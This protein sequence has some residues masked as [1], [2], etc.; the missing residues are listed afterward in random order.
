[1]VG[2]TSSQKNGMLTMAENVMSYNSQG[3]IVGTTSVVPEP[4]SFTLIA[5]ASMPVV[6]LRIWRVVACRLLAVLITVLCASSASGALLA[7]FS[8]HNPTPLNAPALYE[9]S[10]WA[11]Y[12]G[13]Y[14]VWTTTT[15]DLNG[16]F[17][18]DPQ[19]VEAFNFTWT[20]GVGQ[21]STIRADHFDNV[22]RWQSPLTNKFGLGIDG[23]LGGPDA[24]WSNG[25]LTGHDGW[26]GQ[27]YV[28]KKGIAFE[29][30]RITGLERSVTP[31]SQTIRVFGN[32][33]PE[34]AAALLLLFGGLFL[35]GRCTCS[36]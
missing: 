24:D 31:T 18:A 29:G 26:Y 4:L 27:A 16:T 23:L 22:N 14:T 34:P 13:P 15:S 10:R 35:L 7:E 21:W 6:G 3:I 25:G 28:P 36:R 8:W 12:P 19:T 17:T 2:Y 5:L 9:I 30:Y 1:M 20:G 11:G 32:P 33:V